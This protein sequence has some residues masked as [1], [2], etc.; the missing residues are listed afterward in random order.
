MTSG[1]GVMLNWSYSGHT[2]TVNKCFKK[3]FCIK[4]N[5]NLVHEKDKQGT[6]PKL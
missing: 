3:F 2:F 1:L 5:L 6:V 4:G